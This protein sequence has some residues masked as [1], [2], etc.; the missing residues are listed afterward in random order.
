MVITG[1]V[2]NQTGSVMNVTGSEAVL[3]LASTINGGQINPGDGLV[4]V[5][6]GTL[7]GTNFGAGKVDVYS[8]TLKGNTTLAGTQVTLLKGAALYINK[9]GGKIH[10][11][12]YR[13]HYVGRHGLL[14]RAWWPK[15][16][17]SP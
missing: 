11:H 16:P 9:D 14:L 10:H 6:N 4:E 5:N 8:A 7:L 15:T 2:T 17:A 3:N 12:Q 13:H 1:G